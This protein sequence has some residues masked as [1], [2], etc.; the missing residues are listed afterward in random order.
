MSGGLP[1]RFDHCAITGPC[2][3]W[4]TQRRTS[5]R[6]APWS[7]RPV[8]DLLLCAKHLF[9]AALVANW[10]PAWGPKDVRPSMKKGD[11]CR[12]DPPVRARLRPAPPMPTQCTF[13]SWPDASEPDLPRGAVSYPLTDREMRGRLQS[14]EGPARRGYNLDHQRAPFSR[15]GAVP[16][17]IELPEHVAR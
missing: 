5:L 11:F 9:F 14:R 3:V 16:E 7:L 13:S 15:S 4:L 10:P 1:G 2:C 17:V 6:T 8:R 12:H